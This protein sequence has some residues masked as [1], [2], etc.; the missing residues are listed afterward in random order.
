MAEREGLIEGHTAGF[1]PK[2]GLQVLISSLETKSID[3]TG[4]W[5]RLSSRKLLA[6]VQI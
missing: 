1:V 3:Q 5:T 2:V 4:S 6:S